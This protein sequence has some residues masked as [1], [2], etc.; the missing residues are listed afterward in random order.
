MQNTTACNVITELREIFSTFGTPIEIVSDNGPPF[1]SRE[2]VN[3]LKELNINI[4]K[5]PPY[6]PQSNGLAERAV[7]TAKNAL[8]KQTQMTGMSK[9][10]IRKKI[11]EF[12]FKYR[13]T[14]C[15]VTGLTP[16]EIMLKK[17][18]R[19]RLSSLNP[20]PIEERKMIHHHK[21]A[22]EENQKPPDRK[23]FI[24]GESIW[25]RAR[26]S[27]K[28]TPAVVCKRLFGINSRIYLVLNNKNEVKKVHIDQMR[29]RFTEHRH[30]D[31]MDFYPTFNQTN[32]NS[33]LGENPNGTQQQQSQQQ[34]G[35]HPVHGI[36]PTQ[37]PNQRTSRIPMRIRTQPNRLQYQTL[38]GTN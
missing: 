28:W 11:S 2:F 23:Q 19:T 5:S 3:F 20:I 12:L 22:K 14:P 25:I 6:H 30:S 37:Q 13:N 27:D 29:K 33:Q 31:D 15:T 7:Q 24:D 21:P 1:A 18:P 36:Q 4:L 34:P 10:T 26:I 17:I 35:R 38:G 8:C 16:A 9:C 32:E